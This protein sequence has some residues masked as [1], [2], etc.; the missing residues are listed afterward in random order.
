MSQNRCTCGSTVA[1]GSRPLGIVS[2]TARPHSSQAFVVWCFSLE[3]FPPVFCRAVCRIHKT[4]MRSVPSQDE[5]GSCLT[6]KNG[7]TAIARVVRCTGSWRARIF[8]LFS[9]LHHAGGSFGMN[10]GLTPVSFAVPFVELPCAHSSTFPDR[11]SVAMLTTHYKSIRSSLFF[12]CSVR[13]S[14][15][16]WPHF[17]VTPSLHSR[18]FISQT[19]SMPDFC[20]A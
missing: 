1:A 15:F 17:F 12:T 14:K 20:A 5:D 4:D 7:T 19:F 2:E 16:F 18:R 3:M 9:S 6:K 8:I 10:V 11:C 13:S